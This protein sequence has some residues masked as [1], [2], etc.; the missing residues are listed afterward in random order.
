MKYGAFSVK[1]FHTTLILPMMYIPITVLENTIENGSN[2]NSM[3][4]DIKISENLLLMEK[5]EQV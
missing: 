1:D 3:P 2:Y 4:M 5:L